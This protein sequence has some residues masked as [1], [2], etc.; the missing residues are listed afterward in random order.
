MRFRAGYGGDCCTAGFRC[1]LCQLRVIRVEHDREDTAGYV[2]FAPKADKRA[3]VSL[4]PLSANRDLT[5]R[6]K[7]H[8]YSITSSARASNVGGTSRP[9]AFA[10]LRLI[11]SANFVDRITGRSPSFAPL[12]RP[13]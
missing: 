12:R 13:T 11:A 2:R 5:R 10:V 6:S 4:S 9:S 8:P 3:D 7:K 1:E